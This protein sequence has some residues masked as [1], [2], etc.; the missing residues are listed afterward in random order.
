LYA[1]AV[2]FRAAEDTIALVALDLGR[3]PL[4]ASCDRIRAR[5]NEAGVDDV[6]FTATHTHH[7]P[8]MELANAA[9]VE[10]IEHA[11]GDCIEDAAGALRPARIGLG[12]ATVDI[13]HNRRKILKDGRCFMIWRN[14]ARV[15]TSRVD[16]EAVVIKITRDDGSP[17]AVL[18]HHACHPVVMGPSN[19]EYSADYV[20]EMAR[21]VREQSGAECLFLQG[22]CGDINPYLDKTPMEQSGLEAMR[23]TGRAL[24]EA[25]LGQLPSIEAI[26]PKSPSLAYSTTKVPVG[27]RWDVTDP[28]QLEI[29]HQAYGS[30]FEHYVDVLESNLAVPLAT[31]VLNGDLA[32]VGMPGEMFVQYQL[33]LKERSPLRDTFLLGYANDYHAYFPPVRDAVA[34]GYG[35]TVASYVGLGAG[36]KLVTEAE[37]E[38][39]RL[40]GKARQLCSLEDFALFDEGPIPD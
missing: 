17:L 15:P 11:I 22:A 10:T 14:E 3:V 20:G 24:A 31:L 16:R 5:V 32:F 27:T 6:L 2:V 13:G 29:L 34:G 40:I 18:V 19:L 8:V 23:A 9:H 21:I 26:A 37:I 28:R 30:F 12:R 25:V 38:I 35:G 39:G 4:L 7:G 33:D 36:D 1:K